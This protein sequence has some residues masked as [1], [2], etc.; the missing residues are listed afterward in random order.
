VFCSATL[1]LG[2]LV[3]EEFEQLKAGRKWPKINAGDAIEIEKLPYMS[4]KETE[5]VK[6]VVIG[7]FKRASDTAVQF[8]NVS[9]QLIY[10][11]RL[12]FICLTPLLIGRIRCYCCS[13]SYVV[14]SVDQGC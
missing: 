9:C 5:V 6:G 12:L 7:V 13:K 14:Q 1:L 4:A 2:K 10:Y 8:V 11:F 3:N